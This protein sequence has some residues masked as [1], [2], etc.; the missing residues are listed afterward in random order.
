MNKRDDVKR[1]VCSSTAQ[2]WT[3]RTLVDHERLMCIKYVSQKRNEAIYSYKCYCV[4]LVHSW[5]ERFAPNHCM[6]AW[7]RLAPVARVGWVRRGRLVK[8]RS[9]KRWK[10]RQEA[11]RTELLS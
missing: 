1:N 3:N 11:D 6:F 5:D 7:T 2:E 9:A 8:Q 10:T 4:R